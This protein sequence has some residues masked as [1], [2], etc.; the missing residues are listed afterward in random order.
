M[1]HGCASSPRQGH[2]HKGR[3]GLKQVTA[4]LK[5]GYCCWQHQLVAHFIQHAALPVHTRQKVGGSLGVR[6]SAQQVYSRYGRFSQ[7]Q[8]NSGSNCPHT[9]SESN[10]APHT[11]APVRHLPFWITCP[12]VV[13]PEDQGHLCSGRYMGNGGCRAA[14]WQRH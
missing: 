10:H 14:L 3:P 12:G 6:Q 13:V 5:V 1:L 8:L 11:P 2:T 9:L 4:G 7:K